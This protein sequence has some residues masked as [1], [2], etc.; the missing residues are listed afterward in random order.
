MIPAI[1]LVESIHAKGTVVSVLAIS[2]NDVLMI[3]NV[4][5]APL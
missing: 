2:S 1:E 3:C 5:Q 4:V